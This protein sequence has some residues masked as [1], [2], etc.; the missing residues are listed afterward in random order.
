MLG[1]STAIPFLPLYVQ[2]LGIA[3]QAEAAVW[4]GILAAMPAFTMAFMA[5]VWG[6]LADRYGRKPM[7]TRSMILGGGIVGL[8]ALAADVRQLLI[9]R[10]IQG[11]FSG[12]V[13]AARTLAAGIVPA[14]QLGQCLG[15]MATA[16]FVGNSLGPLLGGLIADAVAAVAAGVLYLPQAIVGSAWEL[17][18][19]R[20]LLGLFQG[21]IQP[22]AMAIIALLAPPEQRGWVFGL[23]AT[24]TALGH[25]LGPLL[26]AALAAQ[27]GL[28][29]SFIFTGLAL[30]AAGVWIAVGLRTSRSE[31][32]I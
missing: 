31:V 1:F 9:L 16:A 26:G 3:D 32:S 21:G 11:G 8:M 18:A 7:V 15:L 19:L 27:L 2:R 23:T 4:A 10:T 14:S 17:L 24:A 22:V 25:A 6:A 20:A 12:T 13:S 30:V 28:R 5:P 29:A